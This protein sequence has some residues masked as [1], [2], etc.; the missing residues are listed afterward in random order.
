MS[1]SK[2]EAA[3]AEAAEEEVEEVEEGAEELVPSSFRGVVAELAEFVALALVVSVVVR[4][5]A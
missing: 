2:K 3:R 1:L 4:A 5:L